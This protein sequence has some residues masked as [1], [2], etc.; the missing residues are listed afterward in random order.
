MYTLPSGVIKDDRAQSLG[1]Q[2]TLLT[3]CSAVLIRNQSTYIIAWVIYRPRRGGRLS[4]LSWLT[5][6]ICFTVSYA[7]KLENLILLR[8]ITYPVEFTLFSTFDNYVPLFDQ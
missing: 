3:V 5:G 7:Y 2:A 1:Q 8:L 4:L 6:S